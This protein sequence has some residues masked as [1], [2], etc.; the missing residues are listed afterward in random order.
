[1]SFVAN[2]VQSVMSGIFGGGGSSAAPAPAPIAPTAANSS[3]A[4]DT[5]ASDAARRLLRGRT[6]T[7]LTGGAGLSDLGTTSKTLLGQ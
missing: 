6:S 7:M 2:L 5:A 3:D 1:M 4:M